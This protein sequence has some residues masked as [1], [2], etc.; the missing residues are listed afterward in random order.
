MQK[1]VQR[2]PHHI[3]VVIPDQ[4]SPC[5]KCVSEFFWR[6][7]ITSEKYVVPQEDIAEITMEDIIVELDEILER[8]K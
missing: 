6:H 2:C 3:D 4:F 7:G 1:V 5:A 8:K